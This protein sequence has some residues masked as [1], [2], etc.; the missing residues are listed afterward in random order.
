MTIKVQRVAHLLGEI[1][2]ERYTPRERGDPFRHP[3]EIASLW[4]T[5]RDRTVQPAVT[6]EV[7]TGLYFVENVF[8]DAMPTLY[9]DLE[10]ALTLH[11]PDVEPPLK[12]LRLASWMG[13][14]RD[15]NPNVTHVVTA[16]TLRLHRG[17]AV[18][19]TGARSRN[20]RA[21][22][23]S[24]PAVSRVSRAPCVDRLRGPPGSCC[25]H[26][27]TLS[28]RASACAFPACQ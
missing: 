12:W 6:D 20:C 23:A 3:P 2:G 7:R 4:L 27:R 21:G 18:E 9:E 16:E 14:D 8:W 11:Y 13:G 24:V 5:D 15:G 22:S 1:S 26:R 10:R 25:L 17:L 19:N 28:C